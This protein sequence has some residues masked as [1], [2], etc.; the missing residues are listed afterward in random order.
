[1]PVRAS[2]AIEQ[3]TMRVLFLTDGPQNPAARFRCEQFFP[4]FEQAG[5]ECIERY[6]YGEHY[7]D[8]AASR[9]SNPYR[10]L[11]RL[12][13]AAW[14]VASTGFDLVFFQRTALS[15]SAWP[16]RLRAR[17]RTP[18]IFDFDDAIYLDGTGAMSGLRERAFR[19]AVAASSW[20]IAGNRH[21]A[22]VANSAHKTTVIPSVVDTDTLLPRRESNGPPVVGWMGTASNFVHVR[23]VLPQVLAAIRQVP[24]AT[25]RIISNAKLPEVEGVPGVEFVPWTKERELEDLQSF[26]IGLMPL[27]DAEVSRGKCA[28][29]ILQYMAV[30]SAV[31]ASSVGANIDVLSGIGAGEL[32]APGSEWSGVLVRLM[33]DLPLR[34]EMGLRGRSHVVASYSVKSAASRYLELFHQLTRR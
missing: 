24:G 7:N 4:L 16:E 10:A 15:F 18:T 13:R 28:F 29:K 6:S 21:L 33:N 9:L 8:F 31:V 22:G 14:T 2:R 1:M 25:L 20:V 27:M 12:R 32:V 26:D 17:L 11:C 34:R 30:G 19:Q 5:I 23:L 3:Q